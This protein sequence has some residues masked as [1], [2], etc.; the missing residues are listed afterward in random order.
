MIFLV[1]MRDY[2][3]YVSFTF[4]FMPESPCPPLDPIAC[5][6]WHHL[7]LAHSPWLHEEVGRRMSERLQ[8]L[9]EPP[10]KWWH[11][12][13]LNGGVSAHQAVVAQ[14]KEST[15]QLHESTPFRLAQAQRALTPQAS[16][17]KKFQMALRRMTRPGEASPSPADSL[18]SPPAGSMDMVWAN[19]AL[20]TAIDPQ[21]L[22]QR[23]RE[24]LK[25]DGILMF[26]CLGPDSLR[27]LSELYQSLGWPPA[28]QAF[29]DMHDWGDMLIEAGYTE[30]V[31]DVERISLGYTQ[32]QALLRDLREWGRNLH[33][34]R[35]AG[36]QPKAWH[37]TL[38]KAFQEACQRP[39]AN[40]QFTL[41][42]EVIYGHAIKP[43]P[44]MA[45]A[46]TSHIS[47]RDMRT[48]L[49]QGKH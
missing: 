4:L 44:R 38:D 8:W 36:L 35:G 28:S 47:L 41:S 25:V 11:W 29:T 43:P 37:Q 30:P 26:S 15:G 34:A 5:A 7:P 2:T 48:M 6:R 40:G 17:L 46:N 45:V 12:Q 24:A 10:Q 33:P 49:G 27:E 13:T 9:R 3:V 39:K 14:L 19:M 16:G 21:D 31:M 18:G 23:W 20:H 42:L 22:L 1:R 32:L